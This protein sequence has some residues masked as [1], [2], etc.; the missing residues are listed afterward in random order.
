MLVELALLKA[1]IETGRYQ[2]PNELLAKE[3]PFRAAAARRAGNDHR[4][5]DARWNAASA[6]T[7]DGRC[8]ATLELRA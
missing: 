7:V 6:A 5:V 4:S 1:E 2:K 3:G 8:R